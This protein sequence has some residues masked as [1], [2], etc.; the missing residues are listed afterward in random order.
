MSSRT[1]YQV[2]NINWNIF[3]WIFWMFCISSLPKLRVILSEVHHFLCISMH[4]DGPEKGRWLLD[5]LMIMMILMMIMILTS[6]SLPGLCPRCLLTGDFPLHCRAP[7]PPSGTWP[8]RPLG[9]RSRPG[10]GWRRTW[11][12]WRR[13]GT[14]GRST[15]AARQRRNGYHPRGRD[16]GWD[17]RFPGYL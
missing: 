12:T 4:Q 17:E 9:G 3:D 15:A 2:Q 16:S 10:R 7:S 13:C 8:W 11:C 14:A 6:P 1:R 5:S